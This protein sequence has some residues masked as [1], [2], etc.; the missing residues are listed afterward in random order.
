MVLGFCG[1][2]LQ[3]VV[4]KFWA[5][6]IDDANDERDGVHDFGDFC[7]LAFLCLLDGVDGFVN[8]VNDCFDVGEASVNDALPVGSF[9][10]RFAGP[11]FKRASSLVGCFL[12]S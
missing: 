9:W 6:E 1:E 3:D 10:V 12:W 2:S 5:K 8:F 7:I 4:N 11:R